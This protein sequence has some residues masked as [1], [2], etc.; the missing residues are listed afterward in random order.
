MLHCTASRFAAARE[1]AADA[2]SPF[3]VAEPHHTGRSG[4]AEHAR[5]LSHAA[6]RR[7]RA[8]GAD[9]PDYWRACAPAAVARAA[10]LRG[11]AGFACLP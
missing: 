2:R 8:A 10:R 9:D 11:E 5:M 6:V 1:R 4:R 3:A 7:R